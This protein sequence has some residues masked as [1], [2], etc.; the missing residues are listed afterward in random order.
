MKRILVIDESEAIRETLALILGRE[1]SVVK[2]FLGTTGFSLADTSA[3][4]DL[5]I[6]GVSPALCSETGKLLKFASQVRCAVLFLVDSRAATKLIEEQETV[7]CLA[8]PFNPYELKQKV[9]TL[10]A[11]TAVVSTLRPVP[12]SRKNQTHSNYLS[13][14]FLSRTAASLARRFARTRLS[15]LVS[16]EIG[17]GQ[18]RVVRGMCAGA[19]GACILANAAEV[20]EEF[21]ANKNAQLS[22]QPGQLGRIFVVEEIEKLSV[23]AQSQLLNFI[24]EVE[25]TSINY[26]FL[27]T[28]KIDLLEQVYRDEFLEGLYYRIATLSLKLLPL[29]ERRNE[30]PIIADWF[31]Q[32]FT[33]LLELSRITFSPGA[34]D[35]LRN[36]LWFGNLSE[37]ETVIARTLAVRR[38]TTIEA[39]DLVF[40]FSG[41]I[42]AQ[43]VSGS[44]EF[45]SSEDSKRKTFT[46][47]PSW[48]APG[49]TPSSEVSHSGC[50]ERA[51]E[52]KVLIHELAHEMKNP[53][54]TIKTFAQLLGDRYEDEDFRARFRDVVSSDIERMDDLLEMM[55]EFA[56]FTQPRANRISLEER[57][58]AA[59]DVVGDEWGKRQAA[60]HWQTTRFSPPILADERQLDYILKNVLLAV[61]SQAKVGREIRIDIPQEGIVEISYLRE[62]PGMASIT[63]YLG[64]LTEAS[65]ESILPLR[66][67]LAKQLVQRNGGEIAVDNTDAEREILRME[68]PIA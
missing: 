59:I 45:T 41:T 61:V 53:M 30:I 67:L 20:N 66:I 16:G 64:S 18:E 28:S 40:D 10:L 50:S 55:I 3:D 27:T 47:V 58:R 60:V 26:R 68:F 37:M 15:V 14:P 39:E 24:E 54:V 57:L 35:K 31:A 42:E 13:F 32:Y 4:V 62:G 19:D 48:T 2:K 12:A 5:L 56:D 51:A 33:P 46:V 11:R 7:G 49:Q 8:K 36:Y 25:A 65:G 9:G 44:E 38:K 23:S 29:R 52:L 17:C 21:L 22:W 6:I 1:F 43:E 63:Q 34:N